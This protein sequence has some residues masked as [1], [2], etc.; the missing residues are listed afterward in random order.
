VR[1]PELKPQSQHTPKKKEI[2]LS[3]PFSTKTG[4]LLV[5][6]RKTWY[7]EQ[8]ADAEKA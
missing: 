2:R 7:R 3:K 4:G 5:N 1:S 8:K 6:I